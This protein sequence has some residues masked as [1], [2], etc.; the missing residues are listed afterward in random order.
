MDKDY[1]NEIMNI[2]KS[3]EIHLFNKKCDFNGARRAVFNSSSLLTLMK[4]YGVNKTYE[5]SSGV[6]DRKA[7][8]PYIKQ[9][10]CDMRNA[11][12]Y[13]NYYVNKGE[14]TS[15]S[16]LAYYE[17]CK[18][19][20]AVYQSNDFCLTEGSTGAI[21]AIVEYFARKY[22]KDE[23]LIT[24]PCYYLYRSACKYYRINYKEVSL[25]SKLQNRTVNFTSISPLIRAMSKKTR[26]IIIN[27]PFN[28]SGEVYAKDDLTL[29]IREAKE[30][31]TYV[32]VDEL[33]QDLVFNPSQF[34]SSDLIAKQEKILDNLIVVKGYSKNKNLVAL[35]MGYVFSKN[36]EIIENVAK[37]NQVRQSFPTGSNY[38]GLIALDS[39]IQSVLFIDGKKNNLMNSI[40]Q[41]RRTFPTTEAVNEKTNQELLTLTKKYKEYFFQL[42]KD[43][44]QSYD[45]CRFLLK[46]IT[47]YC[48]QKMSAFNTFFRI[49]TLDKV[50]MF[51]FTLNLY[52]FTGV[53]IEIGPCFGFTQIDWETN[54]NLGFWLR[55][56]FAKNRDTLEEG[57]NKFI[58]F[59]REY[60][61]NTKKWIKTDLKY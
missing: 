56:T 39:F 50:N 45:R 3:P 35:R 26:L 13:R 61:K 30:N 58:L 14:E 8:S 54:P 2:L 37:I 52:V 55:I 19:N 10:I 41:I 43:Y 53:K 4:K 38:A 5:I 32:L 40:K 21:S 36:S 57:I 24:N 33:F 44:S 25:F 20:Y 34:I 51:D 46:N 6:S 60:N 31:N 47:P 16:S 1:I 42:M 15:R 18:F 7:F 23:V 12:Y 27:N 9:A 28:P 49:P 48:L 11:T 22:P 59:S 29:L 17:N